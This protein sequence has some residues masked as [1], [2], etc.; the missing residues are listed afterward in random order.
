MSAQLIADSQVVYS[1]VKFGD[2]SGLTQKEQ[3]LIEKAVIK[4]CMYAVEKGDVSHKTTLS[5][6]RED[7][8]GVILAILKV[9]L[10]V[11]YKGGLEDFIYVVLGRKNDD[12]ETIPSILGLESDKGSCDVDL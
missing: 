8:N 6:I 3:T 5:D 10:E 7:D 2:D 4:N 9:T 11:D 1:P 12:G